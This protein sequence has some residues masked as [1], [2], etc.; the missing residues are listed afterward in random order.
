MIV[1]IDNYDSFTYNLVQYFGE[2]EP[3]VRVYRNDAITV[4]GVAELKPT[5]V[6]RTV[7]GEGGGSHLQVHDTRLGRLGA[8]CCWEHLQPLT[9][10]AM[11][12]QQEQVHVASWPSFSLYRG[13]AY[14]LGPELNGAA[15]QMY[16]AE[17]QCFVIAACA[18]VSPAMLDLL[19]DSPDKRQMLQPGGGFAIDL[20]QA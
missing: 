8:L 19:G 11:F 16:A 18:T 2:F 9:K 4:D 10:Y 1:L 15:S 5:H 6:E 17:G 20:G 14:A 13:M 12:S 3:D 7:F